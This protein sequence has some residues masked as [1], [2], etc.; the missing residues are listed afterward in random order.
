MTDAVHEKEVMGRVLTPAKLE[1]IGDL[2]DVERG[3]LAPENVRSIAVDDA[4]VDT[5]CTL[6]GL[7]ISA[8]RS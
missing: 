5:G 4:L 7:P 8:S 2:L 6:L 3:S 1:N